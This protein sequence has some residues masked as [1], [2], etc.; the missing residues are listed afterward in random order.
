MTFVEQ[1]ELLG[2]ADAVGRGREVAGVAAD[3]APALNGDSPLVREQ[4][5]GS[6]L[7]RPPGDAAMAFASHPAEDRGGFG[8]VQRDPDGQVTGIVE[9]ADGEG[10]TVERNAGQ[11]VVRWPPCSGASWTDSR[12]RQGRVLPDRACPES[13]TSRPAACGTAP[14]EPTDVLGVDN[15][16]ALAEAERDDAQAR[17]GQ[18]DGRRGDRGRPGD[19]LRGC[20]VRLSSPDVDHRTELRTCG[21]ER[22][23]A[24]GSRIGPGTTL[25]N[26]WYRSRQ[27]TV[28]QSVDRGF[29]RS[30][31][32]RPVGPLRAC[33]GEQ[34]YCGDGC[35]I[36]NYA[37]VNR[38]RLGRGVK[39]HHFSYVGDAEVGDDSNIAAGIITCNYDGVR[40]NRTVIGSGVFLGSDTMLVAPV[41]V[42]DGAQTG[43]G[44]VVT[45]DIP[46]VGD[47]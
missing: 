45:R 36:G 2:T 16:R 6:A 17:S 14:V 47:V 40:K 41:T 28:Q 33:A 32:Q 21:E 30:G 22:W 7:R 1:T 23:S 44:S 46:A 11:Y 37:E 43:A 10:G 35:E 26:A 3:E 42:G 34:R 18:H 4:A 15:R 13:P 9:Q 12:E 27:T 25:R 19:D 31:A 38:S 8:R 5:P 39:M 20:I 29:E 24:T